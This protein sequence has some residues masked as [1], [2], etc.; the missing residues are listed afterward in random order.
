MIRYKKNDLFDVEVT[1]ISTGGEGIGRIPGQ[2]DDRGYTLFIKDA[3]PGDRV[4]ARITKALARYGYART[5]QILRASADRV[6]PPCPVSRACGGC[7]L[8]AVSYAR[9]LAFKQQQVRSSLIRIAGLTPEETDRI[10][11]PVAGADRAYGYRNKLQIPVQKD[12]RTGKAAAGFYAGRTH[13]II[14][15]TACAVSMPAHREIVQQILQ[16]MDQNGIP[17]YDE[18]DGSGM[19]RHILVREAQYTGEVS[20]CIVSAVPKLPR[21][22]Q[23]VRTLSSIEGVAGISLNHNPDRTNVILGKDIRLLYGKECMEDLLYPRT[24]ILGD[25]A[26]PAPMRYA[27]SPMAFYQVNPLQTE[28]LYSY[29]LRFAGLTGSETVW[30]LYCGAGTIS[31]FLARSA[32]RVI[33]IEIVP[34]AVADAKRNAQLNGITNAEFYCGAAEELLPS[35]GTPVAEA[36]A[37]AVDVVVVDP[38]RKGLDKVCI[39]AILQAAPERVVYVSCDPAT[40]ARDIALFREG[41]YEPQAVQ[42]VDMFPQTVHI[43]TIVLLQR[44]N[45]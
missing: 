30:D 28:K 4:R 23:L 41:G 21:E 6:E 9:Q 12:P 45:S 3:V 18:A 16:F 44:Q 36:L 34:E 2:D 8:Q 43:E 26:D 1:D 35:A 15:V 17:A 11:K 38:P 19:I 14:P 39:E 20:I 40:L 29:A 27:V 31:L 37:A 42:P 13:S 7:Q 24:D 22:E 33:G 25:T 32:K 10:L 5:E